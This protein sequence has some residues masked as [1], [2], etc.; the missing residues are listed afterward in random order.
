MLVRDKR[1][2][3][4]RSAKDPT[5]FMTAGGKPEGDETE[6]ETLSRELEEELGITIDVS[7]GILKFGTY[8]QA[9]F[10]KPGKYVQIDAF[11]VT[12]FSGE[13]SPQ[14]EIDEIRWVDST[15]LGTIDLASVVKKYIIPEMAEKGF[16]N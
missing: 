10:N 8:T 6:L 9:A 12:D 5:T 7:K 16:I 15:D 4:V 1:T 14:S 2:L 11:I 3:V 13:P